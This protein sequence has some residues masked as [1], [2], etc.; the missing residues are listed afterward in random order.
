MARPSVGAA[1]PTSAAALRRSAGP[2]FGNDPEQ[3][4]CAAVS[5]QTRPRGLAS[6]AKDSRDGGRRRLARQQLCRGGVGD[7]GFLEVA[8]YERGLALAAAEV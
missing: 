7:V 1:T 2:A 8:A 3:T 5:R 6:S 4:A